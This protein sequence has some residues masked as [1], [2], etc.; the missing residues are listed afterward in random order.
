MRAKET[1]PVVLFVYNRPLHTE[2]ALRSLQKNALAK[3][4]V[5]YVFADGPKEHATAEDKKNIRETR[6][7]FKELSGFK[8]V[9]VFEKE[10]NQGLAA[11]VV[12]GV[13]E[14]V[15]KHGQ[16]I[17]LE[18]DLLVS[19]H[20]LDF[21]NR[22]LY[23][24]Q[25][26]PNVYSVTGF[27]FPVGGVEAKTVL[28]PYISTWGWATWKSKWEIFDT[29]MPDKAMIKH[30]PFLLSRFNLADYNY[31]GMLD[32][33]NKSWGIKWYFSVFIRNGLSVFPTQTLVNNIGFD[34]S[35]ENCVAEDSDTSFPLSEQIMVSH[36]STINLVFY[37]SFLNYFSNPKSKRKKFRRFFNFFK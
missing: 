29:H 24:Y 23:L 26:S 6:T 16:V 14:I 12:A 27:M 9:I 7:L 15:N 31:A 30:N 34:G 2:Q 22:G 3:E 4:T 32:L 18:D 19:P 33:G 10:K 37:S 8:H 25:D 5:L 20:F 35:G 11:S 13:T 36:E 17:V 21:M 28:L 1:A